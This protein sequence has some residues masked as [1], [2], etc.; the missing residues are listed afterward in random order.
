LSSPQNREIPLNPLIHGRKYF[1][2]SCLTTPPGFAI[3]KIE[4]AN[5]RGA[6]KWPRLLLSET[7][8]MKRGMQI[9]N[10][11]L[12]GEWAEMCFMTRAVE[13]G[14][15]VN[16]PWGEMARFDFVIG[17][18]R[19]F[20]RVQVKSTLALSNN[21]YRCSVRGGHRPYVGDVFD[22]VAALAIPEDLWYIIPAGLIRGRGCLT[23]RPHSPTSEFFSYEEA[24]HLLRPGI[25]GG[26]IDRIEACADRAFAGSADWPSQPHAWLAKPT[27]SPR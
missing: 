5:S 1:C 18:G 10:R 12:R 27:L 21:A 17:H 6:A 15:Q 9:T 2:N 25:D 26:A 20:I 8:S 14:L 16:K 23:L 3:L 22:F 24:W 11:K 7:G 4:G 13:H 19:H